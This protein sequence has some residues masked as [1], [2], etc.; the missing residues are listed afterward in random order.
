MWAL[1]SSENSK[2]RG[3]IDLIEDREV[4]GAG[5]TKLGEP[6]EEKEGKGGSGDAFSET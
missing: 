1:V 3:H 6:E 4:S 2:C 5:F